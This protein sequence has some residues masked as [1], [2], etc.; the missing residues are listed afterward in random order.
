MTCDKTPQKIQN[1]FDEISI[2]YD[3][4]NNFISLGTHYVIKFLA[5]RKLDIKPRTIGLDLCCGTGDFTK[6]ISKFYPRAKIIGLDF[7]SQMLKLAKQ[8]NPL[9]VFIQ[10][11]CTNL[12]FSEKEF[13]FVTIG[14]GLR[15][16]QNRQK[17]IQEIY[18]VLDTN[19]RLLHLD[20]G[21]HNVF[22]KIFEII[23]P[24][25]AKLLGKNSEHYKYLLKSRQDFPT[26]NEL[27]KEFEAEGFYLVKR[28]DYLFGTISAQIMGK[29]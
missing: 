2:Y 29:I 25:F 8:K 22:G 6:I 14:F 5:I 13:D 21:N 19:G 10:A 4:M 24:F 1:M 27:I 3:K 18:R 28:I 23:V 26:P 12:P 20:F 9:G 16:I 7:S 11:D 15:N 17:A